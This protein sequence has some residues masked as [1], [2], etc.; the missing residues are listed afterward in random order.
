MLETEVLDWASGHLDNAAERV[1]KLTETM[2][3]LADLKRLVSKLEE[4]HRK[5]MLTLSSGSAE[6]TTLLSGSAENTVP[7]AAD[8]TPDGGHSDVDSIVRLD[9]SSY[10]GA[11]ATRNGLRLDER[12]SERL[13]SCSSRLDCAGI[14][15]GAG[16][17]A[18]RRS[19]DGIHRP[20][21]TQLGGA[22]ADE[23]DDS[24]AALKRWVLRL[25]EEQDEAKEDLLAE[26][27][28]SKEE[29]RWVPCGADGGGDAAALP[30]SASGCG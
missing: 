23:T 12:V 3:T 4:K 18:K 15:S 21:A 27:V 25:E 16:D 2:D 22:H 1:H 24:L 13:P 9:V 30:P 5:E 17:A 7:A 26:A 20:R 29:A 10:G 14:T 6:N 8:T 28:G 11:R 19:V